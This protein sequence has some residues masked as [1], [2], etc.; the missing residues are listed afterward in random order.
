VRVEHIKIPVRRLGRTGFE[1]SVLG[2]G[3]HTYP[4]GSGPDHF[5]TPDDRAK[6]VHHLVSSGV[7][8]FDTTFIQEVELLADSLK[9]A[10]I[11]KDSILISL[12]FANGISNAQW[13]Q[14]LRRE[15]ES[16][17]NILG[18]SYAPLFLM[19][20]IGEAVSYADVVEACEEMKRLKE[21]NLIRNIGLSCHTIRLYP[22]IS[23]AIRETNVIDYIMVLFNWKFQQA[24]EE[25]FMVAEEHDVGIV[26]MKI[27][28]WD[29]EWGRRISVFE[30]VDH[31]NRM[32]SDLSLTPA[33]RHLLWCIQNSACDVIVPSMNTLREAE[34]NI[35][36]FRSMHMKVETDDF[37]KYGRRL[38]EKRELKKLALH[39]ESKTI[40]E[41]ADAVLHPQNGLRHLL[42][43]TLKAHY[44]ILRNEGLK[45][46]I[47]HSYNYRKGQ[48][49]GRIKK[50]KV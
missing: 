19:G 23:R 34:E 4:V 46:Y 32:Q 5:M 10:D 48:V 38:W 49:C 25:L 27:F 37:E 33:Q 17:L 44:K 8:Y 47:L 24:N 39:A 22:M 50:I 2:L 28:C 16:R 31:G 9:R 40:R 35:H 21:E 41:R 29:T 13:H 18:Y 12:Q 1:V 36:V 3:G 20:I 6:L 15:I 43:R 14:N 26:V 30:P 45:K 11:K 7:N 42:R